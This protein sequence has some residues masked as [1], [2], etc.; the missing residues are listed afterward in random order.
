MSRINEDTLTRGTV[1]EH[2]QPLRNVAKRSDQ[3]P[4]EN[5]MLAGLLTQYGNIFSTGVGDVRMTTLIEH[6][7]P[8]VE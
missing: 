1:P 8:L 7:I 6:S 5:Q 4:R 3:E 2:M